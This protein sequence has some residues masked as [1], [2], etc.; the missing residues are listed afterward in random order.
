MFLVSS[1]RFMMIFGRGQDI[2]RKG[3][4]TGII[5]I[6]EQAQGEHRFGPGMIAV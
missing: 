5:V 3:D 6:S 2:R 1:E 4:R